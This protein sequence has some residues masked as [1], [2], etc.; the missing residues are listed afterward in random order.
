MTTQDHPQTQDFSPW[1]LKSE[2][3]A[4]MMYS[5]PDLVSR[6]RTRNQEFFQALE[7]GSPRF[8]IKTCRD[9]NP[10]FYNALAVAV[11]GNVPCGAWS[12]VDTPQC[13]IPQNVEMAPWQIMPKALG[14]NTGHCSYC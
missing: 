3:R 6:N 2:D 9:S 4:K 8:K 7:S 1:V 12:R 11:L 10:D 14:L 5:I 13:L